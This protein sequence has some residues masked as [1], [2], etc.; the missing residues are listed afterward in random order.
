MIISKYPS[1]LGKVTRL[2]ARLPKL[3]SYHPRWVTSWVH[4]FHHRLWPKAVVVFTCYLL[5]FFIFIFWR[6]L[7]V[8]FFWRFVFFVLIVVIASCHELFWQARMEARLTIW[9]LRVTLFLFFLVF[10]RF[11]LTS[12]IRTLETRFLSL[13]YSSYEASLPYTS[14]AIEKVPRWPWGFIRFIVIVIL[15]EL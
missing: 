3:T 13:S 8:V 5:L 9:T 11:L 7:R 14:I 10:I 4:R 15:E 2:V 12:T 6:L 1:V